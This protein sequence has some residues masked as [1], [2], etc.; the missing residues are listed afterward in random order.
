M[1]SASWSGYRRLS[2]AACATVLI[3]VALS[4]GMIVAEPSTG[5]RAAEAATAAFSMTR[6]GAIIAD[7]TSGRVF[8]SGDDVVR[9]FGPDGSPFS[10]IE[11]VPGASGMRILDGDLLVA[12]TGDDTIRRYD[13]D[14][15]ELD[16]SW[17]VGMEID[18]ELAVVGGGVWFLSRPDTSTYRRLQR[19]DLASGTV[20]LRSGWLDHAHFLYEIPGSDDHLLLGDTGV[21]P[22]SLYRVDLG[23]DPVVFEADVPPWGGLLQDAAVTESGS[24]FRAVTT[25]WPETPVST[26]H[27][28]GFKFVTGRLGKAIDYTPARGGVFVGATGRILGTTNAPGYD[29]AL[30]VMRPGVPHPT[31]RWPI[32][33]EPA[34]AGVAVAPGGDAAYILTKLD[35]GYELHTF[36][37]APTIS[38]VTPPSV[39][40]DV[41]T[42]VSVEGQGLGS[43]TSAT[44]D[45][46]GVTFAASSPTS[47]EVEVDGPLAP[48]TYDLEL[49][50]PFGSVSETVAVVANEGA[51]IEGTVLEGGAPAPD[52][53]V[54]LAG[55]DL[56]EP[57]LTTTGPDGSYSFGP[58]GYGTDYSLEV[59]DGPNDQLHRGL[60]L[61][62]NE[63][64]VVDVDLSDRHE[65]AAVVRR[66]S[67]PPGEV[68]DVLVEPTTG[69]VFVAVGDEVVALDAGGTVL[70]RIQRQWTA[71]S[72]Q[73][74]D[75][76]V[77]VMLEAAGRISRIDAATLDVTEQWTTTTTT[78]GTMALAGGRLWF[79]DD[80]NLANLDAAD[81][82]VETG[83]FAHCCN[84][85]D[86]Y[87][88]VT[89]DADRFLRWNQGSPA[90]ISVVDGGSEPPRWLD[91][92]DAP[93]LSFAE[94][95][96]SAMH[97][98]A[99]SSRGYEFD[100]DSMT[101]TGIV[102]DAPGA[103]DSL[104]YSPGHG[105]ILQFGSLV[106]AIGDRVPT[107][108]LG[109]VPATRSVALAPDGDRS[110]VATAGGELVVLDLHPQLDWLAPSPT[111]QPAT[112]VLHG[113]GLGAAQAVLVDGA[114]VPFEVTS[115]SQV[116]I[117][118]PTLT[119]G[120]HQVVVET[121]WGQ[122]GSLPLD[123]NGLPGPPVVD[124]LSSDHVPAATGGT[125]RIL[126]TRF[127]DVLAVRFGDQVVPHT[128]IY[129]EE[130]QVDVPPHAPGEVAVSV[131][132]AHGT[133]T[134]PQAFAWSPRPTLTAITPPSGSA[135]GGNVA[136]LEGTTLADVTSVHVDGRAVPFAHTG[137]GRLLVAMPA[138]P[139]GPADVVAVTPK[140]T[141]TPI[142]YLFLDPQPESSD[143]PTSS[144]PIV[145][146]GT[147]IPVAGDF[148]GDGVDD[149]FWYG[150]GS[151][152][153]VLWDIGVGGS[154]VSRPM[155]V[156]GTYVP[157]AG[158]FTGDGVDDIFWYGPGTSPD[159]LSD[160]GDDG[161]VDTQH[162]AVNGYYT[163]VTGDFTGDSVDDIFWYAPGTGPDVLSDY[164]DDGTVETRR[165]TVNG[166]YVPVA[167][168][169]S[170][171]GVD[172]VFW[173]G[174]GTRPDVLSDYG[175]DGTV[176]TQQRA[177]NGTYV[178]VAGDFTGDAVDDVLWYA[179]GTGADVLSDFGDDGTVD[180]RRLAVDGTYVRSPVTSPAAGSTT[181]SGTAE[182]RRPTASGTSARPSRDRAH[183]GRTLLPR[184]SRQGSRTVSPFARSAR[185]SDRRDRGSSPHT[186]GIR[187]S[188]STSPPCSTTEAHTC[189]EVL[190]GQ[191]EVG[192]AGFGERP[193]PPGAFPSRSKCRSS[194]IRPSRCTYTAVMPTGRGTRSSFEAVPSGTERS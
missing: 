147:Y 56:D 23:T 39:V 168:D 53:P 65:T 85:P 71:D 96:A 98:R 175:D 4:A 44:L 84:P 154:V 75:G 181:S 176:E 158:D 89:E 140:E 177:V 100:L 6:F 131:E 17:P 37:L 118:P 78:E 171:D 145:V 159:V 127:V 42:T 103:E 76:D 193:I 79:Y 148:T 113:L 81:G 59:G 28:S 141:S 110:Y 50:G 77:Y 58:V 91:E 29:R 30:L 165:P 10:T 162:R 19:L 120:R 152:G 87:T 34:T 132:T 107:H 164:G 25:E 172:D 108:D 95:A 94:A 54:R 183:I 174:P 35:S 161:T 102:Y 129:R 188:S 179:P 133:G 83:L 9:V 90:Y 82:S 64:E 125:I 117:E 57:M 160:Y 72:L 38:G 52:V 86:R 47:L 115:A 51:R 111:G 15:L 93:G 139:A 69:R 123:I 116:T 99:W 104:A 166:T 92:E 20:A 124:H 14:T 80:H 105:G 173:Y 48:G 180:T 101:P 40:S 49:S 150:P 45:G 97:D 66:T 2:R 122:T 5:S 88:S 137:D 106:S 156:N 135:L 16:T 61:T 149:V 170:G 187:V 46:V 143:V 41:P 62:P 70:R 119:I 189:V 31:H 136:T 63:T 138:H 151:G 36:D 73:T 155:E 11:D 142:E 18:G 74:L 60:T 163:P 184:G 112:V 182:G 7:P 114:E 134:A 192:E 128:V 55:G 12:A 167:G 3:A 8:V 68:R 185:G 126:G 109:V 144:Q 43:I 121:A 130:L 178:P 169:F 194:M 26:M 27:P 24:I 13:V 186:P 191:G 21:S 32:P 1:G 157:V 146:N 22:H 67:L 33:G 190:D 153:D